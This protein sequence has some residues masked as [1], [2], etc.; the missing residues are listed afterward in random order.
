MWFCFLTV[1]D[2]FGFFFTILMF[3]RHNFFVCKCVFEKCIKYKK[4]ISFHLPIIIL[5]IHLYLQKELIIMLFRISPFCEIVIQNQKNNN[6]STNHFK[7]WMISDFYKIA[8]NDSIHFH[9]TWHVTTYHTL[10]PN[11]SFSYFIIDSFKKM[12]SFVPIS[13]P[14]FFIIQ[15][16]P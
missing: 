10:T 14:S 16:T 3:F 7:I 5:T 6:L 12:T 4:I 11:T 9:F 1:N 8:E 2:S 13:N 15:T